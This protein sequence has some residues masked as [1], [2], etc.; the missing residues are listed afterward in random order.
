MEVSV[1]SDGQNTSGGRETAGEFTDRVSLCYRKGA[2][3]LSLFVLVYC[4]IHIRPDWLSA[5][6]H[7]G[8]SRALTACMHMIGDLHRPSVVCMREYNLVI[9]HHFHLHTQRC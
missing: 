8:S 5:W 1:C 2:H 7:P 9:F 6:P 4:S 3:Y